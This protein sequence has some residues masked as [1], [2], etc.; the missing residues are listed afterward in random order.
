M[1]AENT[2]KAM[3]KPRWTSLEIGLITIVCL[4]FVIVI[5]LSILF[6]TQSNGEWEQ[7]AEATT[8]IAYCPFVN[9]SILPSWIQAITA[10]PL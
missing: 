10:I 9:N 5:A 2:P 4:L 1:M 6:A 3:R 8:T 7:T